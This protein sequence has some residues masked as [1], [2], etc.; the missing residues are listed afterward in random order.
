MLWLLFLAAELNAQEISLAGAWS[1]RLDPDNK[2][3]QE[4]WYEQRFELPV[5]LP[6]TLDDNGIGEKPT[7]SD[8]SLTKQVLLNLTRKHRYI[9]VAWYRKEVEIPA[10]WRDKDVE[11]FLERVLW[12]A[13]VWVDGR[14]MGMQESLSTPQRF[15]MGVLKPGRH[16]IVL[17]V[18][19]SKKYDISGPQNFAHAYTDGTQIIWNGVIGRMTIRAL[20]KCRV[21]TVQVFPD[22]EKGTISVRSGVVNTLDQNRKVELEYAIFYG[23]K[24]LSRQRQPFMLAPGGIQLVQ[25][26][27]VRNPQT[28]DEFNPALYRLRLS[29]K[30]D[31]STKT[32]PCWVSFGMRKFSGEQGLLH[33][34]GRRIFLRGTLE[35]A[36]FPLSGYPPMD[37]DGWLKVFASAR[38]YG[39]NHLR[40]HSWCP[41]KAAFEVADSLGFYLQV[42][43][44]L[45][46]TNLGQDKNI[47]RFISEEAAR[48]LNEYG[49]HPS[50]AFWSMGNELEGDFDY[51][52][53]LVD[54][55]KKV[56]SRR[57][58]ASTSFSFMGGHG[59]GP[60]PGDDFFVSQWTNSGW[61][62]GQGIFNDQPPAFDKD[63]SVSLRGLNVP[64]ISHEIGQYSVYPKLDE[65]GKYQGVLDPLNFKAIRKD[66]ERKG[67]DHLW[68]AYTTASGALAAALYKEE[69]ERALKT[70]G[71]S[72]FQL[73]DLHDFP[74]QGTALVGL[75]DAF[76]DSKG[77]IAASEFR[78]F[79]SP[80]VPLARFPKAVFQSDEKFQA[81]IEIANF[82]N[83]PLRNQIVCWEI[84]DRSGRTY[85]EGRIMADS[86]P[87]GNGNFIGDISFDLSQVLPSAY[88]AKELRIQVSL[89][90]TDYKNGWSIWV[91]PAQLPGSG[92]VGGTVC[93]S[94]RDAVVVSQSLEETRQLLREGNTVLFNPDTSLLRGHDGRYT[95]VFWSPVHFPHQP[96][97]MGLMPDTNHPAFEF[98]PTDHFTNWQWWDLVRRSRVMVLDSVYQHCLPVLPVVDNFFRNRRLATIVEAGYGKGRLLMVTMD[99]SKD[100]ATRPEARQL[101]YSLIR[102]M[103]SDRFAPVHQFTDEDFR[104][105]FGE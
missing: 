64:V 57:L 54:S 23:D 98:F 62:R 80:V 99:I 17:R 70:K 38:A 91:Y 45:W 88:E 16:S 4:R 74:G 85:G 36:I 9:G 18:D 35:S 103:E 60:E 7:L 100:L 5:R 39:L 26:I 79:C 13:R 20:E 28:W 92:S 3:V 78:Q 104:F 2:G 25:T 34:N 33:L 87:I 83:K 76:W 8:D 50:F 75:L 89:P 67:L 94:I 37:R 46:I 44:P 102:Y 58:Y 51:L 55:L 48:I 72:G 105:L 27:P 59:A 81:S 97:T 42:E 47:I 11:L 61:L 52:H 40:F 95:P 43:N 24:L 82:G 101:R 77:I 68:P 86:I 90:G 10:H 96:G 71:F 30:T 41:P 6:G 84:H 32:E 65:I 29:I 31:G 56:D 14:E 12:E 15:N 69:I 1:C 49:N 21:T 22:I 63:Y 53:A 66:L 93:N 19:N 73:L